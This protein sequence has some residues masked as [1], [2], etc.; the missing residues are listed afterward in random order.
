[1][2]ALGRFCDGQTFHESLDLW[3]VFHFYQLPSSPPYLESSMTGKTPLYQH[4]H[5]MFF[6]T[7]HPYK[8]SLMFF[9]ACVQCFYL[10][11]SQVHVWSHGFV[12]NGYTAN[13]FEHIQVLRKCI[14]VQFKIHKGAKTLS[15][16]LACFY[17]LCKN[18]THMECIGDAALAKKTLM[19]LLC[20]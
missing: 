9:K 16:S 1:M 13:W 7:W 19:W 4:K 17:M 12:L 14:Y 3:L 15:P 8:F 10:C 5:W 18:I 6:C 11:C 20:K 2:L